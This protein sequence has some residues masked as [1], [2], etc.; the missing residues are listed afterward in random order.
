MSHVTCTIEDGIAHV[1]LDRPEKLNALTLQILDDLVSTAQMLRKDRTLRA[2]VISGEGDSFC[3]GLD[4]GHVLRQPAKVVTSFLPRPW[5]GTNTFQEACWA[6]RRVPVPVIAAVHGH[7]L[8]GGLQIALA[9]DFRIATPDSSWS[10]LEGKWGIIPDMSGIRSLAELVGIDV[11]KR[12]TM[13]AETVSGK[14]A[15]DLGLVTDLATD[16]VVAAVDLAER[17]KARSPD[18]LAAAKRLFN[19]TWTSSPRHTF[20]RERVEQAFLLFAR[21]TLVAREA[22]FAKVSP[23]FVR[24][25]R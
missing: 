21:N 14:E 8:G 10:V 5:R 24:R 11:A 13:T 2:V 3:A 1:R 17:L 9:A 22:A 7:C 15:R 6:W 4:F 12:L 18:Q 25:G 20:A 19:D 16:P 23:Q